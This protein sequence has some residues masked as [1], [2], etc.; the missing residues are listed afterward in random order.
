MRLL[1]S[2]NEWLSQLERFSVCMMEALPTSRYPLNP[3][4]LLTIS[5]KQLSAYGGSLDAAAGDLEHYRSAGFAALLL[6]GN[7]TRAKNLQRMLQ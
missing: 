5:A 7:P 3:R 1:L 4:T 2:Q 6:C